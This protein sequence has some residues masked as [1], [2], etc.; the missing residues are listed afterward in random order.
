MANKQ[1]E[2]PR[3]A[4]SLNCHAATTPSLTIQIY[5][6]SV[7]RLQARKLLNRLSTTNATRAS[8]TATLV[9]LVYVSCHPSHSET[10]C[11]FLSSARDELYSSSFYTCPRIFAY[12]SCIPE[13]SGR[14]GHCSTLNR[15][16]RA[17]LISFQLYRRGRGEYIPN[18]TC[19]LASFVNVEPPRP[20]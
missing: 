15:A 17:G 1:L 6:P 16:G 3:V 7:G 8:F 20:L 2:S 10:F 11:T 19:V 12:G 14:V 5:S 13:R 18:P 9:R 4:N